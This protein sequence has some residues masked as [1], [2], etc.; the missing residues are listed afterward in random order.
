MGAIISVGLVLLVG[1]VLVFYSLMISAGPIPVETSSAEP[2]QTLA[3]QP[4]TA[5]EEPAAAAP[6]PTPAPTETSPPP[7]DT[8]APAPTATSPPPTDTPAPAPT[9]MDEPA[10]EMPAPPPSPTSPPAEPASPPVTAAEAEAAFAKGGCGACHT[11]PGITGAVGQFGPDLSEIGEEAAE[12]IAG[13]SAEEYI[14]ESILDPDAF[15][16][17]KCP[18]GDCPPG[19]MPQNFAETLSEDELNLIIG[20]LST[21]GEDESE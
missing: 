1:G 15:I 6:T 3:E 18:A 10:T 19:A 8:P 20:Y 14:R 21:L 12:R 11:L 4:A 9:A 17:P 2:A 7:T 5:A 16:A 13:Y